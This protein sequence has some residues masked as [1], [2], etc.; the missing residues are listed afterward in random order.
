MP[1]YKVNNPDG[2]PIYATKH[3]DHPIK[4]LKFGS[5]VYSTTAPIDGPDGYGKVL[6]V[7][8]VLDK[9]IY[10]WVYKSQLSNP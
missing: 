1:R 8:E 3:C 9:D 2:T 6:K 5:E 4:Y 10:G 7:T